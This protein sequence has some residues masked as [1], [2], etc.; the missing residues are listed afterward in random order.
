MYNIQI[1]NTVSVL[2]GSLQ[3][4]FAL[5]KCLAE[6]LDAVNFVTN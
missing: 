5:E 6:W 1:T 4:E 3:I 2:Y